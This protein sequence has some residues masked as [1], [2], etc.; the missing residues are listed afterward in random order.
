MSKEPEKIY[1]PLTKRYIDI[2]GTTA[3]KVIDKYKNGELE[4]RDEN[5]SKLLK[6]GKIIQIKKQNTKMKSFKDTTSQEIKLKKRVLQNL[7]NLKLQNSKITNVKAIG[8]DTFVVHLN[9]FT[10]LTSIN[11]QGTSKIYNGILNNEKYYIKDV[12]KSIGSSNRTNM[13]GVYDIELAMNELLASKIYTDIYGI[14]AIHLLLV[15]NNHN[16][17][18]PKYMIASKAIDID[19][20]EPITQDC[21]DLIDNKIPGDIEPFL[22]DCIL[23]NWD[24]GSRGNVGIVTAKRKKTA[25]RIDV[26][27]GLM[28]RAMGERR[29]FTNIPTE[30][31]NFFIQSNKGYKLFKNLNKKQIERMFQIINKVEPGIF[32]KLK[33]KFQTIIDN[34]VDK[35]DVTKAKNIVNCIDIV[36]KRHDFYV[37]NKNKVEQFLINKVSIS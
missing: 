1:N 37:K 27:G 36:K 19:T 20:C 3:K 22:V 2:N 23:A 15:I 12:V 8:H 33:L 9:E 6:I 35:S 24:V 30:H 5:V 17:Q 34:N 13:Y 4:L 28:F 14:D 29:K 32:D 21:K 26:G 10:N 16:E 7:K 18:Y 25:F 31:E 11:T